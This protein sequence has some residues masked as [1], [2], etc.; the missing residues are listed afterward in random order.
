MPFTVV[1]VIFIAT[2]VATALALVMPPKM[3]LLEC[4]KRKNSSH[5]GWNTLAAFLIC[6]VTY[7]FTMLIDKTTVVIRFNGA[8]PYPIVILFIYSSCAL[9]YL[10]SSIYEPLSMINHAATECIRHLL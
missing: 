8:T 1:G 2:T 4:F 3:I 9:C 5:V 7:I 10:R 6:S